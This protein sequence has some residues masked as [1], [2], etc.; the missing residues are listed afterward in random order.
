MFGW[1]FPCLLP[2]YDLKSEFVEE[3]LR[4]PFWAKI[5]T[6]EGFFLKLVAPNGS[7]EVVEVRKYFKKIYINSTIFSLSVTVIPCD[8]SQILFSMPWL[9][10]RD[11]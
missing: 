7:V 4:N 8:F 11:I 3:F 1:P 2:Q 10:F 6:L 9:G 5:N